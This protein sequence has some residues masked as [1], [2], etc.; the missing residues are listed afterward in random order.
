MILDEIKQICIVGNSGNMIGS[1]LGEKIDKYEY[2]ARFGL[3]LPENHPK[4]LKDIGTKTNIYIK[5]N[6][7]RKYK[8]PNIKHVFTRM[9]SE[10]VNGLKG[11]GATP[12]PIYVNENDARHHKGYRKMLHSFWQETK[13]DSRKTTSGMAFL[14]LCLYHQ[15]PEINICGFTTNDNH[16][17]KERYDFSTASGIDYIKAAKAGKL[18]HNF[19]KERNF[20]S[21]LIK[22]KKI[23]YLQ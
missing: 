14:L 3:G 10:N 8:D 19:E 7:P 11:R 9:I 4:L 5:R 15:V 17:P 22:E 12:R 20:I 21:Q 6:Q 23:N 18:Q 16:N 1:N 13:Y 2:V